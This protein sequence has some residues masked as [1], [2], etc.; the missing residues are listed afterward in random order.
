MTQ[1]NDPS[2]IAYS[3][4]SLREA[5]GLALSQL[6]EHYPNVVVLDADVAGGTGAHHFLK[7]YPDRF[8]P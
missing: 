6:A 5:F 4:D 3:G 8:I 1:N 2:L 7:A